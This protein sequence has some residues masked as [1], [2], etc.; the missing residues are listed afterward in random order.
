L[1]AVIVVHGT[2]KLLLWW[3]RFFN[4]RRYIACSGLHY[5]CGGLVDLGAIDRRTNS[6]RAL[7]DTLERSTWKAGIGLFVTD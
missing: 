1:N 7:R 6:T 3:V 4:P 2:T 5:A